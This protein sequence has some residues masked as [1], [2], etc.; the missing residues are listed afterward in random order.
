ML[1]Y[2][3]GNFP[4]VTTL[5]TKF[6]LFPILFQILWICGTGH[7]RCSWARGRYSFSGRGQFSNTLQED[8]KK[9]AAAAI[10]FFSNVGLNI[11]QTCME[12]N[13]DGTFTTA[14]SPFRQILFVQAKQPGGKRSIPVL[15]A[16]LTKKV[17]PF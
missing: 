6:Q 1:L 5:P 17:I 13:I 15:F 12:I 10:V 9:N 2:I 14:P 4:C 16:L 11:L 3:P 7:R 8:G